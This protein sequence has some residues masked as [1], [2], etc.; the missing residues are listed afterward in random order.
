[1]ETLEVKRL[2]SLPNKNYNMRM[3]YAGFHLNI[4]D[5]TQQLICT[6]LNGNSP[7][8]F[9]FFHSYKNCFWI[10]SVSGIRTGRSS[11]LVPMVMILLD[12]TKNWDLWE[13]SQ[14]QATSLAAATLPIYTFTEAI[15]WTWMPVP[16]QKFWFQ[17]LILSWVLSARPL[18]TKR[19]M[20]WGRNWL[21]PNSTMVSERVYGATAATNGS[22]HFSQK[23]RFLVLTKPIMPSRNKI[24]GTFEFNK[25]TERGSSIHRTIPLPLHS[26]CRCASRNWTGIEV[27]QISYLN[28]QR[29]II[30]FRRWNSGKIVSCICFNVDSLDRVIKCFLHTSEAQMNTKLPEKEPPREILYIRKWRRDVSTIWKKL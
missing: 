6:F 18:L 14:G 27:I 26:R 17:F 20:F 7:Y 2:G 29:P 3:W 23:S 13:I 15:Y 10:P 30:L 21:S 12:S 16:Y 5:N 25:S 9:N 19:R 1:M 22:F 24:G 11:N 28:D 8:Y 4:F